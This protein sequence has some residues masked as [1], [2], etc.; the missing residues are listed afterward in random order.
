VL[1]D[2]TSL[3]GSE[4]DRAAA[5]GVER[6]VADYPVLPMQPMLAWLYGEVGRVGE[7]RAIG[8]ALGLRPLGGPLPFESLPR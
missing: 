6:L 2:R 8:A 1:V 5:A 3:L 4:I 7:A